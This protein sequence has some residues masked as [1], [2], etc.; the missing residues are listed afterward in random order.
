MSSRSLNAFC[1]EYSRTSPPGPKTWNAAPN[2]L[3]TFWRMTY[4]SYANRSAVARAAG[5]LLTGVSFVFWSAGRIYHAGLADEADPRAW[6][7][8]SRRDAVSTRHVAPGSPPWKTPTPL[9]GVVFRW[10]GGFPSA[11]DVA[12]GAGGEIT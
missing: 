4:R 2:S 8:S 9:T 1:L 10:A 3:K 7:R 12:I 5:M 6:D 11:A